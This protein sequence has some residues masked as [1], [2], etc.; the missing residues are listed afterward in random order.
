MRIAIDAMGGDAAPTAPVEGARLALMQDPTLEVV[1]VGPAD[2]LRALASHPR[3]YIED[4]PDVIMPDEPPVAAVR[5]KPRASLVRGTALV[6]SREVD[7]L[8]SAGNTGAMMAAGLLLLGRLAGVER[9]ALTAV[10]PTLDGQGLLLLDVGANSEARAP[11]LRQF[12]WMGAHYAQQVLGRQAPRVALLNIGEEANKGPSAVRA[13]YHELSAQ[14][15]LNFTGNVESRDLLDGVADVVVTDGFVG[16]VVLK[17]VEG[18]ALGMMRRIRTALST[19][20]RA[21]IGG[22]LARPALQEV[23]RAMDYEEVGGVPLLGLDGVVIKA[24]GASGPRAFANAIH[25]A[26]EQ[27][28]RQVGA[29]IAESLTAS[30]A[31]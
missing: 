16:N 15:S 18:T 19:S 21:R 4:A 8:V 31:P 5:R 1:V 7:G 17:A 12:A 2:A 20:P 9:P 25:R 26:V 14:S 23:R 22:L 10:L 28:R 30:E 3:L 24:H 29:L 6:K 11:Q 13:A 27:A